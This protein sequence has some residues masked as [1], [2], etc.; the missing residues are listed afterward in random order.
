MGVPTLGGLL[1]GV[2][3]S[4]SVVANP[5]VAR[6]NRDELG[7]LIEQLCGGQ[8]HRIERP[9]RFDRK[10]P[11]DASE[12]HAIDVNDEAAAF[13]CPQPSNGC[14]F[15][16]NGQPAGDTC[17]DDGSCSFRKRQGR[18]HVPPVSV[19]RRQRGGIVF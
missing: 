10:W 19:E 8:V 12:N 4:P 13:E 5:R 14:L 17:A 6:H 15:L 18:R 11:A 9:N 1:D 16:G 3:E 7:W 2:T